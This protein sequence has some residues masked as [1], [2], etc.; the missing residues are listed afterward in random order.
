MSTPEGTDVNANTRNNNNIAWKNVTVV[1][2]FSGALNLSSILIRNVFR[3]RVLAGLRFINARQG[4]ASFFDTGRVF[5]DIGPELLKRWRERGGKGRGI[6]LHDE[7]DAVRLEIAS[8]DAIIQNIPLEP[9]EVFSVNVRFE[10]GRNYERSRDKFAS[11]DLI[12]IGKPGNDNAV[13]GGQRF[14]LD[15]SKLVLVNTGGDWRYLDHGPAPDAHWKSLG[16]DDSKWKLGKA[17]LGFGDDPVTTVASGPAGR[18]RITT[19]FRHAFEVTDPSFYDN[20]VLR[21]KRDDGAVVYLNGKEV[22]R[23]N[24]PAGVVGPPTVAT[25]EVSGLEEKVFFPVQIDPRI[26]IRGK[27]VIAVEVH[28][29]SPRSTDMSFDLELLANPVAKGFPPDIGFAGIMNGAVWQKGETIPIN[30]EALDGDGR[31]TAVSLFA[32]GKLIGESDRAPFTFQWR[33]APLGA[34]RLQAVASDSDRQRAVAFI[35]INVVENLPPAVQLTQPREGS[36]FQ[37]TES[38]SAVASASDR[39][40]KVD[41]VEFYIRDADLFDT[42]DRLVGTAKSPPYA[43]RIKDLAPGH[44]ILIAIAWDNQGMANASSPV[45]FALMGRR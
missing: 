44:Y 24:L 43:I 35:T 15:L 45:H 9:G 14:E 11:F 33:D 30:I 34:H 37:I 20:L 25:R 8:P 27:N 31:V 42:E 28:Q 12:Q 13:V 5:V 1:D 6:K 29:N 4:D 26:L 7:K 38:I 16:F 23:V 18:R 41:R 19:Y 22:H 2:N 32:D 10:L 17:E 21:L 39:L 36:V 3:E 40:G